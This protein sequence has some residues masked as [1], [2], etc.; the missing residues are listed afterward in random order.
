[1]QRIS[2]DNIQNSSLKG[3][4]ELVEKFRANLTSRIKLEIGILLPLIAYLPAVVKL[5]DFDKNKDIFVRAY[6]LLFL[7][8][9]ANALLRFAFVF[10]SL[11]WIFASGFIRK[12]EIMRKHDVYAC[13][14]RL[15]RELNVAPIREFPVDLVSW[16][17]LLIFTYVPILTSKVRAITSLFRHPRWWWSI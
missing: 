3:A 12:R 2:G 13:E 7:P 9:S 6:H 4:T 10:Q 16:C 15:L 5:F 11:I 14:Q 1:L 8:H 17:F